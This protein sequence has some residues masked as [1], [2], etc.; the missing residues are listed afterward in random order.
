MVTVRCLCQYC[1]TII[2]TEHNL[3]KIIER[4]ES[5]FSYSWQLGLEVR[6]S[7]F[8][9]KS[10]AALLIWTWDFVSY[11]P[12]LPQVD[13]RNWIRSRK[14]WLNSSQHPRCFHTNKAWFSTT[15]RGKS[16]VQEQHRCL[17]VL[18]LAKL[19]V[20]S[21]AYLLLATGHGLV[22]LLVNTDVNQTLTSIPFP[23]T[24]G[25]ICGCVLTWEQPV[26][27]VFHTLMIYSRL[28]RTWHYKYKIDNM[29]FKISNRL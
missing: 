27:T 19:R 18:P 4:N 12:V 22:F 9:I 26:A 7:V 29:F 14:R 2:Y 10:F 16:K 6:L 24:G 17:D 28:H 13:N 21:T 20:K 23:Y 5:V 11:L 1:R 3:I 15:I 25:V 8:H